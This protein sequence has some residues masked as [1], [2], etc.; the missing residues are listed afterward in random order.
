MD[1]GGEAEIKV[2]EFECVKGA[3]SG[4]R[5]PS[6][7][8]IRIADK[9]YVFVRHDQEYSSTY[10]TRQGG[11]GACV[12]QT[13]TAIIVGMWEKDAEMLHVDGKSAGTQNAADC[14]LM[15]EDMATL[16]KDAGF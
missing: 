9:K 13:K 7:A 3:A 14:G 11:G 6:P 12:A 15:V 10:M 8:G 16:L 1:D 4:S 5:M 2:N